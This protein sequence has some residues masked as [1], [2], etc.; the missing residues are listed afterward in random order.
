MPYIGQF[1]DL[2]RGKDK[3][4]STQNQRSALV[5]SDGFVSCAVGIE[6]GVPG[7][8]LQIHVPD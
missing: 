2:V 1:D 6:G 4:R 5:F 7:S 3:S 8:R